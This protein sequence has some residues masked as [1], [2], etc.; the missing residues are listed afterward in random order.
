MMIPDWKIFNKEAN[1]GQENKAW[2]GKGVPVE[3]ADME[4]KVRR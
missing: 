3:K 2:S 4:V 1:Q